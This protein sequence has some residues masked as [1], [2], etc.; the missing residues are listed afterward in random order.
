[1]SFPV[2]NLNPC[3]CQSCICLPPSDPPCSNPDCCLRACSAIIACE[4]AVGPCGAE[5]T[6]DL[7]T[8]SH[9]TT[10]CSGPLRFAIYKEDGFFPY[11]DITEAG[12][13]TWRTPDTSKVDKFGTIFFRIACDSECDSCI[14]ALESIGYI[15]IG[16]KNLCV[17]S[18]CAV[19]ET[20][21]LC[22]GDCVEVSVDTEISSDNS[23]VDTEITS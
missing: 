14:T 11:V 20:C 13:L 5:G 17:G 15:T 22:T 7:T 21:D 9:E 18:T 6:F 4:N 2:P 12:I 8:L 23:I 1:M 19:S 3:T 16:V 10:G